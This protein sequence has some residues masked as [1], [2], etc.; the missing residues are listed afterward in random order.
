[1]YTNIPAQD[2]DPN[3]L[4][5]YLWQIKSLFIV[6]CK[7]C[8]RLMAGMLQWKCGHCGLRT[9]AWCGEAKALLVEAQ[10]GKCVCRPADACEGSVLRFCHQSS[11]SQGRQCSQILPLAPEFD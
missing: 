3:Q 9:L 1:M 10:T 4:C 2:E 5:T 8:I 6:L 7:E 11:M